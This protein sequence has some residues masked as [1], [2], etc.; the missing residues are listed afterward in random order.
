LLERLLRE[1]ISQFERLAKQ[2]HFKLV[3]VM[4]LE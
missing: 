1:V 4:L 2:L 3:P